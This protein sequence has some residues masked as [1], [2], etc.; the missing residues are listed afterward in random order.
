MILDLI[1]LFQGHTPAVTR[2]Q[3][4]HVK[5]LLPLCD[6]EQIRYRQFCFGLVA[7][8]VPHAHGCADGPV[9]GPVGG[10]L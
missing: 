5:Q 7:G 2:F 6:F 1:V 3:K 8:L 10:P 9:G 4:N